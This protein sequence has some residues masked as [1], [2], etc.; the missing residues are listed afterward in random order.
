ML[1]I[2]CSTGISQPFFIE[3]LHVTTLLSN[4]FR[5]VL[6]LVGFI[7]LH[8]QKFLRMRANARTR[9]RAGARL[10]GAK[11]WSEKTLMKEQAH[12]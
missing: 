8:V 7:F 1:H 5:S 9:V 11:N 4:Y 10:F 12:Y 6:V 2:A 3:T